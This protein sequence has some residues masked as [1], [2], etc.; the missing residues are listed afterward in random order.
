MGR[1]PGEPRR[2]RRARARRLR[3]APPR[4]GSAR[5]QDRGADR[6]RGAHAAPAAR[7]AQDALTPRRR[8]PAAALFFLALLA[9]GCGGERAAP[10]ASSP[11]AVERTRTALT[12]AWRFQGSDDLTGAEAADYDDSAWTAVTIPHN[13]GRDRHWRSAW[14]RTRFDVATPAGGATYLVFEG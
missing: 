11:S 1:A 10:P 14:Y 8:A 4:A 2:G 6:G 13:W 12:A 9:W 5:G 3:A 7:P